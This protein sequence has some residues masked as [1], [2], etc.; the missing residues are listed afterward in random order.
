MDYLGNCTPD[1][2]CWIFPLRRGRQ[3]NRGTM[4]I[5]KRCLPVFLILAVALS[6]CVNASTTMTPGLPTTVPSSPVP[7]VSAT[8]APPQAPRSL[9]LWVAPPFAPGS[10]SPAGALLTERLRAFEQIHPG[11][12]IQVRVKSTDGPSGLL[13]TLI[14]ANAAAPALLPDAIT[15]S[16]SNLEDAASKDLIIA[17]DDILP[18]PETPDWY[19]FSLPAARVAGDFFGLPLASEVNILAYRSDL[20]PSP[21]RSWEDL[22][23]EPRS[24]LFPAGDPLAVFT[25]AQYLSLDGFLLNTDD[26]PALNP[27]VLSDVLT[28]YNAALAAQ[29]L[30]YSVRQISTVEQSWSALQDNSA[31]SAVAP[32]STY[33][34]ADN[35]EKFSAVPLPTQDGK[36]IGLA[37]TWSWAIVTQDAERIQIVAELLA[38]LNAPDFLGLWTHSLGMLPPTS[39]SLAAWPEGNSAALASSLVTVTLPMP[40]SSLRLTIGPVLY[41]AVEAVLG[42]GEAPTT[43]AQAAAEALSNP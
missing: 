36:G 27:A 21:P 37:S 43:A 39:A 18:A 15:F 6:S 13:E 30:P 25:L 5:I 10:E 14:A 20:Y 26:T 8:E 16:T 22:L 29:I 4:L 17:L 7:T 12:S 24:F 9:T 42:G 19:D 35:P 32:L 28:T 3:Y 23:G 40:H 34:L 11:L 33:L 41:D 1:L 2:P 31:A 38:W